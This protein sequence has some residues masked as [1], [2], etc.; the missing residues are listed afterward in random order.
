LFGGGTS[1]AAPSQGTGFSFGNT[2]ASSAGAGFG[3]GFGTAGSTGGTFGNQNQ[4]QQPSSNLFG[5]G[6]GNNSAGQSSTTSNSLFG[7]GFGTN[8][9][10]GAPKPAAG[11]F[12]NSTNSNTGTGLFGQPP[13][14]NANAGGS[15]FGN[16]TANSGSNLFGASQNNQAG[17][18]LFGNKPNTPATTNTLFGQT[19]QSTGSNLFGNNTAT[20]QSGGLFGNSNANNQNNGSLFGKPA[21]SNIGGG[22]LFGNTNSANNQPQNTMFGNSTAQQQQNNNSLFGVNSGV[23]NSQNQNNMQQNQPNFTTSINDPGAF[24][25]QPL[26]QIVGTTPTQKSG[27]I[28]TPLS[29]SQKVKRNTIIPAYKLNPS[30]SRLSTPQRPGTY[31]FSYSRYGTPSSVSSISTTPLGF[32]NSFSSGGNYLGAGLS[33]TLNKSLSTSSLR[34]TFDAEDSVLSPGAFSANGS[35]FGS[36]SLKKLVINRGLRNDLFAP[37]SDSATHGSNDKRS[38]LKKRVSFDPETAGGHENAF[39]TKGGSFTSINPAGPSTQTSSVNQGQRLLSQAPNTNGHHNGDDAS[40]TEQVKGNELAIVEENQSPPSSTTL[41]P[42]SLGPDKDSE[43]GEYTSEPNIEE[44]KRMSHDQL[45][46]VNFSASRVGIGSVTFLQPVDFTSLDLDK[47]LGGVIQLEIRSCTVYP[48]NSLKPPAGVGLNVPSLISL[49]NT[50]VKTKDARFSRNVPE[51]TAAERFVNKLKRIPNTKFQSYDEKTGNWEFTVEHFTTY[52]L[53][54]DSDDDMETSELSAPPDSP[55]A[56]S[57]AARDSDKGDDSSIPSEDCSDPDDTFDFKRKHILPGSFDDQEFYDNDE[58]MSSDKRDGEQGQEHSFLDDRS[59][60]SPSEDG[61]EEPSE[62]EDSDAVEEHGES[63]IVEDEE[64]VGS[65]PGYDFSTEL[66]NRAVSPE[67]TF[68]PRKSILKSNRFGPLGTPAKPAMSGDWTEQLQRTLSP[69]KQDRQALRESQALVM[70]DKG[71]DDMFK[72]KPHN[73]VNG[74]GFSTPMDLMNSLYGHDTR[75]TTTAKPNT[76]SR[77]GKNIELP[78]TVKSRPVDL[79][80]STM[81]LADREY[82]DSI[83]PSWAFDSALIYGIPTSS[84]PTNDPVQPNNAIVSNTGYTITGKGKDIHFARFTSRDAPFS[85]SSSSSSL[86]KLTKVVMSKSAECPQASLEANLSFSE[87]SDVARQL[88]E[89]SPYESLV[90]SL[91]DILFGTSGDHPS[92]NGDSKYS[93]DL[94]RKERLSL[95]WQSLVYG[96]SQD[97]ATKAGCLEEV[98]LAYLANHNIEDACGSLV[99]GENYRLATLVSMIG[100]DRVMRRDMQR[101]LDEWKTAGTAAEISAP[102]RAIYE[103]LA[104][105]TCLSEG[106]ANTHPE[107]IA[108]TFVIPKKFNMTWRQTFGL[109]LWYGIR[110]D[111][112]IEEAIVRFGDDLEKHPHEV[113]SPSPWY[114]EEY[115]SPLW[116]DA[117]SSDRT[118][119][120]WGLMELYASSRP[121]ISGKQRAALEDILL[122]HTYSPSPVDYRLS[123]LLAQSF[124]AKS[125]GV[126]GHGS[127]KE[128][129]EKADQLTV[130][131]AWQLENGGQWCLSLLVLLHLHEEQARITAARAILSR[132]SEAIVPG[133]PTYKTLVEQFLIPSSWIWEAKAL[134]ARALQDYNAEVEALLKAHDWNEAHKTICEHVAPSAILSGDLD[135]LNELLSQFENVSWV[136]QWSSGGQVYLDYIRLLE[137]KDTMDHGRLRGEERIFHG[138]KQAGLPKEN[139][140]HDVTRRL[141]SSLKEMPRKEFMVNVAVQ[142]MA[143]FVGKFVLTREEVSQ[144]RL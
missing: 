69:R 84:L 74:V 144:T 81:S 41:S 134:H 116:N 83:K 17:G 51:G 18:G 50:F 124:V 39:R 119:L 26:F 113:P 22:G 43:P 137:Y 28:A 32:S 99:D 6:F 24:G 12:G 21:T 93:Q 135:L 48:E 120:L 10:Q 131:Y 14:S 9:N 59:V 75:P 114:A 90:W 117:Y 77:R 103:L 29:S 65:Y 106:K 108:E 45:K 57:R 72:L 125:I 16:N 86:L 73:L 80:E 34:R 96:T 126:F 128:S 15:L 89:Q 98:V 100:G 78:S 56:T 63:V 31:A 129:H 104:G 76:R 95:F 132:H 62:M 44:L 46:R 30:A 92:A 5:G 105:N 33:R 82:H 2:N 123:W 130:D 118:D 38:N 35:K 101:Q 66:Q 127:T 3:S 88:G 94:G 4:A 53:Q 111:Q 87:I 133:T 85:S 54:D 7:G 1:N 52:G 107:D 140:I 139:G 141:L 122:P 25:G 47:V 49:K 143:G 13:A 110:P 115:D 42:P 79:D 67:K 68:Q 36:A 11:L 64:I 8:N 61:V 40:E 70:H 142:E 112:S 20:N 121:N 23:F 102:I 136:E 27:P 19:A 97:L 60:G 71:S 58:E 55:T 37:P 138:S 109:K 91:V